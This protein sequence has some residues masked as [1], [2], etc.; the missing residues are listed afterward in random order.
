MGC[1]HH[2]GGGY[3]RLIQHQAMNQQQSSQP[4][5]VQAPLSAL[6]VVGLVLALVP[7]CPFISLLGA[8]LGISAWRRIRI[9]NGKL[10][11]R[12][13]ALA[14]CFAGIGLS[15]VSTVGLSVLSR[16]ISDSSRDTMVSSIEQT[17]A[18]AIDGNMHAV[19]SA[20]ASTS[21]TPTSAQVS[22]FGKQMK[23]RYGAFQRF[24][25]TTSNVGGSLLRQEHEVAGIFVFERRELT[26]SAKFEVRAAAGESW[27]TFELQSILIEDHELGELR[28]P[29]PNL[30]GSP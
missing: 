13:V 29:P 7:C 5:P 30:S 4:K 3:D 20:W 16:A 26:G 22:D 15:I 18:T 9:S 27:P 2:R 11:G 8:M 1:R 6:A 12:R 21:A 17:I 24:K 19:P 14:A 10:G 23:E 28:L 25:M